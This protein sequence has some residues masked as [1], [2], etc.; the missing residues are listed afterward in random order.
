MCSSHLHWTPRAQENPSPLGYCKVYGV[1]R[2]V[3]FVAHGCPRAR[4]SYK[5]FHF[6]GLRAFQTESRAYFQGL[7]A[8]Q[9]ESRAFQTCGPFSRTATIRRFACNCPVNHPVKSNHL[10]AT[11]GST[12][13][14]KDVS[15]K[16]RELGAEVQTESRAFLDLRT[17]FP[18]RGKLSGSGTIRRFACN[19]L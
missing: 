11:R 4:N 5:Q 18:Y 17:V 8:F 2:S 12:C 6:Q 1:F 15:P 19:T 13:W 7:R 3:V 9:T 14:H 16:D 10:L